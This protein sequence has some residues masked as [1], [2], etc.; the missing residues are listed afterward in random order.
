MEKSGEKNQF[1]NKTATSPEA[2]E[3]KMTNLAYSLAAKQLSDGTASAQITMY[4]VKQGSQKE[5]LEREK[6]MEEVKLIKAKTQSL[7]E[8]QK[9]EVMFRE[10]IDAFKSYGGHQKD[11]D[12]D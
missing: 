4:F 9:A 10:A 2:Q 3:R 8:G 11:I 5:V 6:L 7:E 12:D 1:K